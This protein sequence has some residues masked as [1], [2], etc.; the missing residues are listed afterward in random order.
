MVIGVLLPASVAA[1]SRAMFSP[2][3]TDQRIAARSSSADHVVVRSRQATADLTLLSASGSSNAAGFVSSRA[4]ARSVDLNLFDDVDVTAQLDHIETVAPLGYAWVGRVA[5]VSGSEVV[6]AVAGG[7]L[8]GTVRT[9]GKLYSVGQ[10]DGSYTIA[11][12]NTAAIPGDQVVVPSPGRASAS[13]TAAAAA[14]SGDDI[15][16]LLYY[17]PAVK[18]AVGGAAAL[19]SY[20]AGS[21]AEVN[22]V[23][24]WSGI[25]ARVR[26]VAALELAYT[27][28][29]STSTD[30]AALQANPDVRAARNQY[31]ADAVSLV[32]G[33]DPQFSG[34]AYVSV[35]QGRGSADLAFS[36]TTYYSYVSYIYGLAHELGHNLGC[37]HEMGNNGGNDSLGAFPFS[38]GYTDVA[39]R[40][41][42]VMSYGTG[43]TNCVGLLEFSNPLNTYNGSPVGTDSQDAARTINITRSIV[44]NYRSAA[45]ALTAPGAPS[46][47]VATASGSSIVLTW[48]A[49]AGG[50]AS[51]YT[52][53]AGSA[54]GL[55]NLANFST[56]SAAAT[57]SA[58]G[59]GAGTYYVRV[60]ATNAAGT[61]PP[62]NEAV[63]VVR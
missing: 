11:E 22:A 62:S 19:S 37:L 34:M 50:G 18:Q 10:V 24:G 14:D 31:G 40:F 20:I 2:G 52:I 42:D 53:E 25:A 32:V 41:H 61:S 57:F 58:S 9:P 59:V 49:P 36:V 33:R 51:A 3:S 17:T 54:P 39:H 21:I 27:E 13:S 15:D 7:V 23:Y 12:I 16:L 48:T 43:C 63:L 4:A 6:L 28:S 46:A 35:S 55:A 1:Q 56:N 44:A 45:G 38:V 29:G 26:L 60:R 5:G 47:L 8:T 30:L